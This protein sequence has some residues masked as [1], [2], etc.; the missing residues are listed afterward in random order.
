[1]SAVVTTNCAPLAASRAITPACSGLTPF[2]VSPGLAPFVVVSPQSPITANVTGAVEPGAGSV[3]NVGAG[4][5]P[6]R[7]VVVVDPT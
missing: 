5:A 3:R 6:S 4:S 7:S 1:M 2:V